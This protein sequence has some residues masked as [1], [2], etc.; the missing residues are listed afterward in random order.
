MRGAR[1]ACIVIL[2]ARAAALV[3]RPLPR[4]PRRASAH[5]APRLAPLYTS[6][7]G[8]AEAAAE[9]AVEAALSAALPATGGAL[10]WELA[11]A[12]VAGGLFFTAARR[13]R[14][15]TGRGLVA[16]ASRRFADRRRTAPVASTPR[17]RD[18]AARRSLAQ[19]RRDG[20]SHRSRPPRPRSTRSARRTRAAASG[21]SGAS[22][23]ASGPSSRRRSRRPS[24]SGAPTARR[25][26]GK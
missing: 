23:G 17:S 3:V 5:V 10:F 7:L 21:S 19:R 6:T 25:T 22:C 11:G 16:S 4:T 8:A 13:R 24:R 1:I 15:D 9:A 26:G 20:R 18:S 14:G 2:T 12:F